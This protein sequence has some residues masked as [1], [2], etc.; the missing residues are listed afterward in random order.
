MARDAPGS[1]RVRVWSAPIRA[2]HWALAASVIAA[3]AT[4]EGFGLAHEILGY[5][6]L[7]LGALR[8][9][10]GFVGRGPV[11]FDAFVVGVGAT[12]A[13]V[14]D[15][16]RARD[17]RTLGH[18]PLGGWMIVA[19][20]AMTLASGFSGWLYT[21]DRF[22][23]VEWVEALHSVTSHAFVVL[24]PLHVLGALVMSW[25][26]RENLVGSMIHG[27]KRN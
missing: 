10:I 14:R 19:L 26:H 18:N 6:A 12:F 21:T 22:W 11:R 5:A 4:H 8:V 24:V 27:W 1:V 15:L 17:H 13:H 16:L 7:A 25:R 20:L 3:F 9:V 2:L 23:G